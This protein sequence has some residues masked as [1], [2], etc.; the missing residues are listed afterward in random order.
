MNTKLIIVEGL[1]GFGKSTTANLVN[2]ILTQNNIEAE[3]F[4]EGNL[5]HPA[6]YDGVACFNEIEFEQLLSNSGN[7][8]E[9][10]LNRVK[11]K[12]SNYLLPYIK[13]KDEYGDQFSDELFHLI[14]KNDVYELP[15]NQ[16]VELIADKWNDFAEMALADNKVYIFECCFIQNPLTIGMVKYNEPKEKT[17]NYVLKLEKLIEKLNPLLL[18]VEQ[19]D[20]GFSFRKAI[21]ERPS[22]W[23]TFFVDYYTNQ[24]YGKVHNLT[25]VEGTLQV[26]EARRELEK[27]IFNLLTMKKHKINNTNYEMDAYRA[28]LEEKLALQIVK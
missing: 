10:L 1:P 14:M 18:Y 11:T 4:L 23:S 3:L 24:G 17:I 13:I 28:M 7:F 8:K 15:F 16:N 5:D 12:G 20:L 27:K 21:K 22:Q 9:V 2:E 19:D 6:D 26:L 25:G